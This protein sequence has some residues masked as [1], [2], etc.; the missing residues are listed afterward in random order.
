MELCELKKEVLSLKIS[1]QSEAKRKVV[2]SHYAC[3]CAVSCLTC[4]L[5]PLVISSKGKYRESGR[6]VPKNQ[7]DDLQE[8]E[9]W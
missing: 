1:Q 8:Q 6:N 2:D 4:I 3:G 5:V 7:E 9:Q